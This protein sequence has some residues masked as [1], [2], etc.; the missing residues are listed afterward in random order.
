MTGESYCTGVNPET[1]LALPAMAEIS[2]PN[3][4]LTHVL[5][6]R[7]AH[8]LLETGRPHDSSVSP[9]YDIALPNKSGRRGRE[10]QLHT[11]RIAISQCHTRTPVEDGM[12]AKHTN[13]RRSPPTHTSAN[14]V[15]EKLTLNGRGREGGQTFE[16]LQCGARRG[17]VDNMTSSPLHCGFHREIE[18]DGRNFMHGTPARRSMRASSITYVTSATD[19]LIQGALRAI[20]PP[21]MQHNSNQF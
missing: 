20:L 3:A 9:F 17:H 15:T 5:Y 8:I 4:T 10:A 19:D 21:P 12:G 2:C 16:L 13:T 7:E 18:R 1:V 14:Y 6:V 11:E